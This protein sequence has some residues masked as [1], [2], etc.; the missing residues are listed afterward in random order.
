MS[1]WGPC[2]FPVGKAFK[3]LEKAIGKHA[4]KL[5]PLAKKLRIYEEKVR[6]AAKKVEGATAR[7]ADAEKKLT[8]TRKQLNKAIRQIKKAQDPERR[9]KLQRK[10][11]RLHSLEKQQK[12]IT[13]TR[14][15]QLE[16]AKADHAATKRDEAKIARQLNEV[17]DQVK[18]ALKKAN[19]LVKRYSDALDAKVK[20]IKPDWAREVVEKLVR[21][22]IPPL[23]DSVDNLNDQIAGLTVGKLMDKMDATKGEASSVLV[24]YLKSGFEKSIGKIT[25]IDVP[26]WLADFQVSV[27]DDGEVHFLDN[28]TSYFGLTVKSDVEVTTS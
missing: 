14:Q 12:K 23:E 22:L 13:Q 27:D 4:S 7:A 24:K 1:I 6:K 8:K 10:V 26:F 3:P 15:N 17:L 21:E 2:R 25:D 19:N 9:K 18:T 16:R 28:S 5:D 11:N 20:G